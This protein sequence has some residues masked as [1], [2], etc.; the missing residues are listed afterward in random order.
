MTRCDGPLSGGLVFG[1]HPSVPQ[2]WYQIVYLSDSHFADSENSGFGAVFFNYL[3]TFEGDIRRCNF[4]NQTVGPDRG[5]IGIRT[6]GT[7]TIEE[8]VLLV[9]GPMVL[10]LF[11]FEGDFRVTVNILNC[12]FSGYPEDLLGTD[13]VGIGQISNII[14]ETREI[15]AGVGTVLSVI[16]ANGYTLVPI[17]AELARIPT[18]TLTHT[19]IFTPSNTLPTLPMQL[20]SSTFANVNTV[21][22]GVIATIFGILSLIAFLFLLYLRRG[23][24]VTYQ[25]IGRFADNIE[26]D[27][28]LLEKE[29]KQEEAEVEYTYSVTYSYYYESDADKEA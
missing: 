26:F 19:L 18:P 22:A 9:T 5:L 21:S 20:G 2:T 11:G 27:E 7:L 8:S 13:Y 23:S 6:L 1:S 12:L 15:R 16:E 24:A 25:M 29:G 17:D 10:L 3:N 14:L 4:I 28:A